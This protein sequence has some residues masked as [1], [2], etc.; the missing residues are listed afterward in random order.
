MIQ[1][2]STENIKAG[3]GGNDYGALELALADWLL[4]ASLNQLPS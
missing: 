3:E 4:A 2:N 1:D